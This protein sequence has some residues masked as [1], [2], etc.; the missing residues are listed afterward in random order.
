MAEADR[1][2]SQGRI[3]HASKTNIESGGNADIRKY[4]TILYH[5]CLL[6]ERTQKYPRHGVRVFITVVGEREI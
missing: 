6:A 4:C 2:Y 1:A 5:L 3:E